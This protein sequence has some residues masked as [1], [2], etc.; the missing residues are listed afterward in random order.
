MKPKL[1]ILHPYAAYWEPLAGDPGFEIRPM[2]GGRAV[3][4]D[5]KLIL[6]FTCSDEP[7]RGVLVCTDRERQAALVSEVPLLA[8]H[9]V[10]SKWLY[11][12]ESEAAFDRLV[13]KLVRLAQ[14]RDLRL[15]VEAKPRKTAKA[16]ARRP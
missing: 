13:P 14:R 16:K 9:P 3:Y 7:W 8:P 15:G 2:F 4:L 5:G 10:L 6:F 11:L 1:K 12:P